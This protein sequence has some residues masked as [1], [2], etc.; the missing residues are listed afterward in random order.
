MGWLETLVSGANPAAA[1]ISG[2]LSL[3][4]GVSANQAARGLSREQMS[5][6][7][8]MSSTAHQ[9]EVADLRKAGLNPIL[10]ALGGKGA[11]S[12]GGQTAPVRNVAQ[13][14]IASAF[15]AAQTRK[16]TYEADILEPKATIAE[17]VSGAID[18]TVNNARDAG[19]SI[20]K[21]ISNFVEGA[22]TDAKSSLAEYDQREKKRPINYQSSGRH[23]RSTSPKNKIHQVRQQRRRDAKKYSG[24]GKEWFNPAQSAIHK[25]RPSH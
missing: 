1:A 5:F 11:S 14:A 19:N 3:L 7:E 2:G 21:K 24:R 13:E 23:H 17:G 12:P 22:F 16:A 4:G 18:G 25:N 6:Q 10:S 8:R 9:R 20:G 15:Q